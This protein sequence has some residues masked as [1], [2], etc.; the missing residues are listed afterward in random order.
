MKVD[1]CHPRYPANLSTKIDDEIIFQDKH[2]SRLLV[3]ASL[4]K[5]LKRILYT[6]EKE[7]FTHENTGRSTFHENNR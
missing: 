5:I 7:N 4:Q 1:N 6:E 2:K 3:L